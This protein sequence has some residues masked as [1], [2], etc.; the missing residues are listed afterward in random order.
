MKKWPKSF[1][2]YLIF[3]Q[4]MSKPTFQILAPKLKKYLAKSN[5]KLIS[6]IQTDVPRFTTQN[7]A[8][9]DIKILF[10][11]V[12]KSS[13]APPVIGHSL[14]SSSWLNMPIL[15]PKT[16]LTFAH[17]RDATISTNKGQLFACTRK[18]AIKCS[19]EFNLY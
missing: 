13:N 15:I 18:S 5:L 8:L 3:L 9:Q 11:P 19:T 14:N 10:T 1:T 16:T 2:K 6:A 4:I 7:S 12:W 17:T